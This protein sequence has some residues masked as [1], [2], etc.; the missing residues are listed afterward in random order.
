MSFSYIFICHLNCHHF[1]LEI[2]SFCMTPT[3]FRTQQV[4]SEPM[5]QMSNGLVKWSWKQGQ[6]SSNQYAINVMMIKIFCP[7]TYGEEVLTTFQYFYCCIFKN[8]IF[9]EIRKNK[10]TEFLPDINSISLNLHISVCHEDLPY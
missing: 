2:L 7:P 8:K 1:D 3:Q 5:V 10:Y 4:V 9:E 6:I